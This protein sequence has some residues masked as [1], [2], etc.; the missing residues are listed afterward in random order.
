[1]TFYKTIMFVFVPVGLFLSGLFSG[2]TIQSEK[3]IKNNDNTSIQIKP[4]EKEDEVWGIDISHHQ[5]NVNWS[6]LAEKNKPHFVILKST[7]GTSLKDRKYSEYYTSARKHEITVGTYHFFSYRSKGLTQA[8]NYMA[9]AKIQK[10]DIIP[11]LDVEY[12]RHMPS[13]AVIIKEIQAFCKEIN[14]KYKVKPILY[15][16][17]SYYYKYLSN[18]F[19]DYKFWIADYQKEPRVEWVMWQHTEKAKLHGI[20][21]YVDRN[22]LNPK[23]KL[24]DF[25]VN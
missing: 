17:H 18:D 22:I 15:C 20:P 10:G 24:S 13:R 6:V 11:I 21:E 8:G 12:R 1:M 14:K 19:K 9:T 7:E 4:E 5:E 3:E 23:H 16:N 2:N 25:I